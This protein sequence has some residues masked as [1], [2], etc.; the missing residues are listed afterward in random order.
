MTG[1]KRG[2]L[3]GIGALEGLGREAFE[4]VQF[5]G[6]EEGGGGMG[7]HEGLHEI[8]EALLLGDGQDLGLGQEGLEALVHRGKVIRWMD[9]AKSAWGGDGARGVWRGVVR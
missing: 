7:G 5:L 2:Y 8:G 6:R 4:V 1:E 9:G 3:R